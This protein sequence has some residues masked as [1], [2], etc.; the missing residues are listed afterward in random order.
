MEEVV[1]AMFKISLCDIEIILHDYGVSS[2]A[3]SFVELQRYYYEKNEPGS[4]EVRLIVKTELNDGTSVV[5]RFKNERDVSLDLIE[6]QSQFAVL[7]KENGI[8]TPALYKTECGFAKWYSLNGYDVIVTVEEFV[9]GELRLVD[10][11]IAEKMGKLLAKTHNIAE[12]NH[13]HVENKV[14][15]DPFSDNDLFA[16]SDFLSHAK[17]F[18][19]I[20][21]SLYQSIVEKYDEYMKILSPLHSESRYAVQGDF[22]ECN[23]YQREPSLGVFDFNRC[24]DNNLYCDAVMQSVFV[25]RLMDYPESYADK[26]ERKIL[27]AFLKGYDSERPFSDVNKHMFPYLYA[28]INAFWSSDIK[29]NENS[30]INE[31]EKGNTKA[32]CKWLK[33]ILKR[34]FHLEPMPL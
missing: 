21:E 17:K 14:L 7:L 20:D 22:S 1:S 18:V 11:D 6:R 2:K 26:N 13:F 34:L 16:V 25:A 3:V 27:S 5:I 32:V 30:L 24:G 33:E 4:K 28:I 9:N 31:L 10:A 23:L 8:A 29:W 19:A 12:A 15:F